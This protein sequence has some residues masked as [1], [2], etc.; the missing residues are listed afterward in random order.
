M[1]NRLTEFLA[2]TKAISTSGVIYFDDGTS[3]TYDGEQLVQA[4]TDFKEDK[5][6]GKFF[7]GKTFKVQ[8]DEFSEFVK[9]YKKSIISTDVLEDNTLEVRTSIPN[10]KL[11]TKWTNNDTVKLKK[12]KSFFDSLDTSEEKNI[13]NYS[14]TK[15]EI[16]KFTSDKFNRIFADLNNN[17]ISFSSDNLTDFLMIS[18]FPKYLG[19]ILAS[20][21]ELNL[22][23]YSTEKDYIYLIHFS[24][25]NMNIVTDYYGLCSDLIPM[26]GGLE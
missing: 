10:V 8:L 5:K 26:E 24:V 13:F 2:Q 7:I 15:D 9:T 1:I 12:I 4:V 23:I 20:T 21:K 22:K 14:F 3:Y 16:T 18:I 19:K 11:E 6:G 17:S 25:K